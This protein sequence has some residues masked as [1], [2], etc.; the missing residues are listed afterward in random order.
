MLTTVL[1]AV[2]AGDQPLADARRELDAARRA[3]RHITNLQSLSPPLRDAIAD[4]DGLIDM[5]DRALT[6]T[7]ALPSLLGADEPHHVL[8]LLQNA[9]EI[10]PTGGFITSSV[11]LVIDQGKIIELTTINSDSP[12]IDRFE[13]L[14]Y[15]EPPAP[16]RD[17]MHLPIWAFRDA[18]WSPDFPT[19]AAKAAELYTAGR[20]VPV[21]TVVAITQYTFRDL[22]AAVGQITLED[23][24]VVHSDNIIALFQDSWLEYRATRG[25]EGRKDFIPELAPLLFDGLFDFDNARDV[26]GRMRTVGDI[27]ERGD[28]LVYSTD[29]SIQVMMERLGWDGSI[30]AWRGDYLYVVDTNVGVNK[31]DLAVERRMTYHVNLGRLTMPY[32][33]LGL[34]YLNL[35]DSRRGWACPDPMSGDEPASYLERAQDCYADFLRLY[36]PDETEMLQAPRFKLPEVYPHAAGDPLAGQVRPLFDER[37]KEVYGGL[38]VVLPGTSDMASFTYLLPP[39]EILTLRPDGAIVYDLT[40]QKQPGV[41]E[42]P[43]SVTIDLPPGTGL[44][45]VTPEPVYWDSSTLYFEPRLDADLR[46]QVVML[47]PE[48]V[49]QAVAARLLSPGFA[50]EATPTP[51]LVP[52]QPPLPTRMP[53]VSTPPAPTPPE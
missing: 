2:E 42:Y 8:V 11:Y 33:V 28:L 48:D 40:I 50:P 22:V 52:T 41:R 32:G 9:D 25:K 14:L 38:M 37:G 23:G 29:P 26:L 3:R 21:D 4:A 35:S 20:Q 10:R 5:L 46:L 31:T 36:L 51:R 27:A 39:R 6:A 15:D 19:S 44:V 13:E 16:L 30:P 12:D 34:E 18:N 49:Q 53:P 45:S 43:V 17:Y 1:E 7:E 24:T 47:V